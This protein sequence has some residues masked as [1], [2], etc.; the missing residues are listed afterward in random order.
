MVQSVSVYIDHHLDSY[1]SRDAA[2][3]ALGLH[4][5]IKI[6]INSFR[7]NI[8]I[9]SSEIRICITILTM[10]EVNHKS[11]LSQQMPIKSIEEL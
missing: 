11:L 10:D 4:C 3:D 5:L 8:T 2:E 6:T 7:W 9:N 1:G